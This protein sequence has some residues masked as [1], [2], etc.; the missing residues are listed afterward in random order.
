MDKIWTVHEEWDCGSKKG[1]HVSLHGNFASALAR[2]RGIARNYDLAETQRR[3]I[4]S[5]I[6]EMEQVRPGR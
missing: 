1:S 3:R 6:A 2:L 5:E 4:E